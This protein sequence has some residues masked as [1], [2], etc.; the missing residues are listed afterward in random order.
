[1]IPL[2]KPTTY[3]LQRENDEVKRSPSLYPELG[4]KTLRHLQTNSLSLVEMASLFI[5]ALPVSDPG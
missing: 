2:R 3:R 4:A 5:L 1:M